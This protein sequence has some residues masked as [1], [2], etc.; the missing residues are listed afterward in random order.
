[1]QCERK[2]V[3]RLSPDIAANYIN[4]YGQLQDIELDIQQ[5]LFDAMGGEAPHLK[6]Q[7]LPL[8][9]VKVIREND[10]ISIAIQGS[11]EFQW[12][13]ET[14]N[15][16]CQHQGNVLAGHPLVLPA[17]LTV[18]YHSLLLKQQEK[19]WHCTVI[20]APK[21]CYI[22]A[23]IEKG[24]KLWGANIQ[25]YTLRS[26]R[27]WGIGDVGDLQHLVGEIATR[28]GS[29]VGLNPIHSLFPANPESA[30]PYS[31]SS[32]SWLN[33]I[34]IDVDSV[35]DFQLSEQGKRW[36]DLAETQA[37]LHSA[38]TSDLVD[39]STVTE[40]KLTA[41]TFAWQ[42]F[43]LREKADSLRLAFEQFVD[44]RGESLYWQAAFDALH[45]TLMA[46]NEAYWGWPVWP[47]EYRLA[48][49]PSVKQFCTEHQDEIAFWSWLQW[50]A[51]QQ[52]SDC[53]QRC[54]DAN[55][56]IGLYRDLAVGVTQGGAETWF[57]SKLYCTQASTGAPPDILGPLGQNWGVAPFNPYTLVERA[58]APFI[59]LIRANMENCGA[60][61]IDHV[62]SLLRLW[63]VPEGESAARGAY[64]R[65]PVD[66]LL[67][68]L[69]LE[70][71]R[72]KC[73]VIG[74][75]LGI[76]PEEIVSKLHDYGVFSYKVLWFEH[77]DQ[78]QAR[79]P[80]MWAEQ[81]M[82]VISTHDMATLKGYWEGHDFV[83]GEQLGLYPDAN[84]LAHLRQDR[85]AVKQGLLTALRSRNTDNP[86][87]NGH[88]SADEVS[89]DL[90]EQ[91]HRFVAGSS[92]ALLGLQPEDWLGIKEPVNI[93]GTSYE[94][95]NWRRKLT[96]TL[97]E[98][99]ASQ[100][101]NR[102]I[103]EVDKQ[104]NPLS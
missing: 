68:I 86:L 38:R 1:M 34:Y 85:E 65:Y 16:Q 44:E 75:D 93:P 43:S 49:S 39:Y 20:V 26:N 10:E 69:A 70:S 67:A 17:N 23:E 46:Q 30:S 22:P 96:N 21:R 28:G 77:D 81:A 32:R 54:R 102:L 76:V 36:W 6:Q 40:L 61:R 99:F 11:G 47:E 83:L 5:K 97:E 24:K 89:Q 51:W 90:V 73:M 92:S 52:F 64:V 18:G 100:H 59:D 66:D 80:E 9:T 60:L 48:D 91:L 63:W 3:E 42:Q 71:Q 104:R 74:E 37:R 2:N 50:L 4:A 62:M 94:Y 53:W 56:P 35:A 101:V 19:Q 41:L 14:E 7:S 84:M 95:P 33:I 25:L 15:Q 58:Y 79:P 87:A 13:F 88:L 78:R 12:V 29:F 57:D 31:P 8:P 98:M 55:M 27:N 72:M 45:A 103:E 82:A